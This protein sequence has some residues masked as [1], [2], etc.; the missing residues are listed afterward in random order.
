MA[1][2]KKEAAPTAH[3]PAPD[4]APPAPALVEQHS[5]T[6]WIGGPDTIGFEMPWHVAVGKVPKVEG[7]P[8]PDSRPWDLQDPI[9]GAHLP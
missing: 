5:A 3:T 6:W 2:A 7:E 9:Q 1:R 8:Y 4:D